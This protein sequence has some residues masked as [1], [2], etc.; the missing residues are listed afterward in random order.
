MRSYISDFQ[1][2]TLASGSAEELTAAMLDAY[3]DMAL[4]TLLEGAAGRAFPE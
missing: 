4:E 1:E 3:P 2:F